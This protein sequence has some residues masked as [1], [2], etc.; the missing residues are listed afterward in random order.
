MRQNPRT[1]RAVGRVRLVTLAAVVAAVPVL[2]VA[3]SD[4]TATV[5]DTLPPIATTTT[6]TTVLETTTTVPL[7]YTVQPGDILSVVAEQFGVSV[8]DIMALN[9]MTDPDHI[10][11]GE[12]LRIPQPGEV[13]PTTST[14][15]SDSSTTLGG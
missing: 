1:L 11:V 6:S 13:I 12:E 10:E 4:D 9:N 14:V 7:F 8:D 15:P 5:S 3:C 2:L